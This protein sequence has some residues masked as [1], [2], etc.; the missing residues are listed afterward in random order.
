MI[1]GEGGRDEAI[2]PLPRGWRNGGGMGGGTTIIIER[3]VV[4]PG[5]T[6]R[7]VGRAI[8]RARLEYARAAG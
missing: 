3:L 8:E 2:V 4:P 7:D 1:F 5:S 6:M